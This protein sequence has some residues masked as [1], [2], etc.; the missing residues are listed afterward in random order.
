MSGIREARHWIAKILERPEK[1]RE[2][3]NTTKIPQNTTELSEI[4]RSGLRIE[5]DDL[6][7]VPM[8]DPGEFRGLSDSSHYV[9]NS[10]KMPGGYTTSGY[11]EL[12]TGSRMSHCLTL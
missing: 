10:S 5:L 4:T 1:V 3:E 12:S 11:R 2:V 6:A 7:A 8:A 9:V